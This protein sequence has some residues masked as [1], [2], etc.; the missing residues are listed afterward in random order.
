MA[1]TDNTKYPVYF[2]Y[3][4]VITQ[5]GRGTVYQLPDF[6][7]LDIH[8]DL[9]VTDGSI[10]T[11]TLKLQYTNFADLTNWVDGVDVAASVATDTVAL[12]QYY[13]FG[14]YTA[15]YATVANTNPVTITVIAVAK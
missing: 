11:T 4:D 15:I 7:I 5:S 8:Y 14:R 10:N 3:Q 9:D 1:L 12:N 13:N 6:E 2:W